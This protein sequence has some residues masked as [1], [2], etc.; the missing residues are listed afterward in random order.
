MVK[1]VDEEEERRQRER[2]REGRWGGGGII[3]MNR[4]EILLETI[5]DLQ[6]QMEII[7]SGSNQ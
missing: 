7:Y 3:S 1:N 6:Y 4:Q 5:E 2:R